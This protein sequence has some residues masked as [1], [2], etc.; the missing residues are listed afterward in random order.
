MGNDMWPLNFANN[1]VCLEKCIEFYKN[2]CTYLRDI[3]GMYS[4]TT[5]NAGD[6]FQ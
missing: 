3:N 1:K 2:C 4:K 6:T 5:L